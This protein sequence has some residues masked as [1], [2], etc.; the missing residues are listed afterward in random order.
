MV[1]WLYGVMVLWLYGLMVLWL[2]GFIVLWFHGFLIL[3]V[4]VLLFYGLMFSNNYKQTI[5]CFLIDIDPAS[6]ICKMSLD[7]SSFLF[8]APA[9]R[10]PVD[11]MRFK[12]I[13]FQKHVWWFFLISFQC[14]GVS[15]DKHNW[16]WGLVTGSEIPKPQK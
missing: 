3:Y 13:L 4:M 7:G 16:F 2:C 14:S 8:S 9:F 15:K 1:V 10:T 6:K 11:I 5:S 12:N